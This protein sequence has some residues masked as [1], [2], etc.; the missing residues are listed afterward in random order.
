MGILEGKVAVVTGAGRGLGRAIS[1]RFANEGANV[2]LLSR[3]VSHLEEA[4]ALI[5]E[6]GGT[7]IAVPCDV[8]EDG[9]IPK[10]IKQVI[11]AFGTVD[12]L[13]N[14]AH[15]TRVE[16]QTA[17]VLDLTVE[18]AHHQFDSGPIQTLIAMQTCFPY[19]KANSGRVI[20][21]A[22]YVGVVGMKNFLPYAMAKESIR[23]LTRVAAKEWGEFGI[24]VNSISPAAETDCGKEVVAAGLVTGTVAPPIARFGS[25]Y[26]DIAPVVAFLASEGASYL[27]GY[28]Y[29]IDGGVSIDAAR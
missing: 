27:T 28:N 21:L 6:S 3:T 13:V 10:A 16:S 29:M 8:M 25:P 11:D 4:T 24:T 5:R 7:A 20:N 12:I 1:Q 17:S 15:D 23:A 18:Q 14:N 19:L 2:A 9:A 26:D 22:S